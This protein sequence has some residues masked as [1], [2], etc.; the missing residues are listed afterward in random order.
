M[1]Q[2]VGRNDPCPCGSGKK[3]KNCCLKTQ[4]N[5]L[6][7]NSLWQRLSD[8]SSSLS[9]RLMRFYESWEDPEILLIAWD[10]FTDGQIELVEE[11][12]HLQTFFPW[13]FYSFDQADEEDSE[14]CIISLEFL[15]EFRNHLSELEAQYIIANMLSPYSFYEVIACDP[16]KGYRLKDVFHGE[17]FDVEEHSGSQHTRV[18]ELTFARIVSVESLSTIN[19]SGS[20][21]IPA[22]YKTDCIRLRSMMKESEKKITNKTLFIWQHDIIQLYWEIF[23]RATTPPQMANTDGDPLESHTVVY[24]IDSPAYAFDKLHT[25]CIIEDKK[26]LL[27]QAERDSLGKVKKI[28][29]DWIVE[30]NPIHKGWNNTV[31]GNIRINGTKLTAEVNSRSRA[32]KIRKEIEFR[33]GNHTRFKFDKVQSMARVINT[34]S[35]PEKSDHGKQSEIPDLNDIP[36]EI[37]AMILEQQAA[38]WN[39]WMDIAIPALGNITPREAAKTA[40]GRECLIALLKD[41][42]MMDDRV[43]PWRRQKKYIERMRKELGLESGEK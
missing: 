3:Y 40:D 8:V 13:F 30:G 27:K 5:V 25:L 14:S 23:L 24:E 34:P 10:V 9:S 26:S 28:T 11:S 21:T 19:G 16:G 38:H 39:D 20:I 29:F 6:K 7:M 1:T 4:Q 17:E 15:A 36:E 2:K 12:Q 33:L 35:S 32:E 22:V 18:G 37:R 43:E 42:E 31:M 41:Y